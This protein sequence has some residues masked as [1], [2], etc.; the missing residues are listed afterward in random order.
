MS[1]K[2]G[3]LHNHSE[4]SVRD[5]AMHFEQM[6]ARAKELGAPAIALTDHGIL[7]GFY[8]FMKLGVE[9]EI[10]TIPGMEAYYVSDP[11]HDAKK[12]RQHL[13]LMAKDMDG[14]HAI[15]NAVYRSY[16]HMVTTPAGTFPRMTREILNS[17]FGPKS[18][19]YGHVIA[20]SACVNGVLAQLLLDKYNVE[21]ET[22]SLYD[23][24]DKYHPI[25][26]ELLV[27]IKTEKDLAL[28]IDELIAERESLT[29]QSKV[30]VTGLKCRLKTLDTKSAEYEALNLEIKKAE[31]KKAEAKTNSASVKKLIAAKKRAKT[32]YSKSISKIKSSAEHWNTY[33][34]KIESML[35]SAKSDD[36]M[37]RDTLAAA[38]DFDFIFGHG[39]FF[40]ELQYHHINI[41]AMTMPILAK[42]A[43]ETGIPVVA[44]NDA[45]YATNS[46]EDIRA[47]TLVLTMLF[48]NQKIDEE[49]VVLEEGYGELYMKTDEELTAVLSEIIDKNIVKQAMSNIG[50]IIDSC[51]VVVENGDHYP[52]FVGGNPG[53]TTAQRLRRLAKT[54]ISK[55]YPGEMWTKEYANRMEYE[56][57]IIESMGYSDYLC[58]VQDF[59]EY[60]RSL[61][62]DCPEE[63]GYTIG[64]GRG[65][66]VGSIV[67]YL[68]GITSVDPMRYGLLFERFLNPERVSMP[69]IDSD[70]HTEVRSKVI[71]YVKAKYGE[72]AV[73]NILTKGTMAGKSAIR[74]VGR[75]TNVPDSIIDT[76][77]GMIPSTSNA[78]IDDAAELTDLCDSNPVAK[79]LVDDAKLVEGTIVNYGMHAAG[80][81][82]SDNGDVSKYVAV[83]YN[84]SKEQWVAQCDMG[85]AEAD[86]GLLKMDFLGLNNLDIITDTVRRIKRNYGISIDIEAV[87][88]EPAVFRNI[89]ARGRTNSVFQFE[90]DGM[91]NMLR[92]FQPDSMEDIILLVAA[93][94]PGP[95][96]DIPNMIKVKHGEMIPHYI[97]DG[98]EEILSLTYG[99]PIYQEQ[100]MQIFNKVA[101]FSLGESDIIRRA[102]S[103]K[104][105]KILTDPKTDYHGKFITG[106]QKRGASLEDAEA[107]WERLLDFASYAFNKSHAAAYAHVSYYTA[108]L[109]YHYP[110]EYMCSVM[111]RTSYEKLPKLVSE[112]RQMGLTIAAPDI[113]RSFNEF[114]NADKTVLFGFGNIKGVGNSGKEIIQRRKNG[115]PF[116]SMKDF[117]SRSVSYAGCPSSIDKSSIITLIESGAFD[118]FCHGNRQSLMNGIKDLL[119]SA[120]KFKEQKMKVNNR[121]KEVQKLQSGKDI[122]EKAL[123]K[124]T[125]S[126]QSAMKTMQKYKSLYDEHVFLMLPEDESKRLSREYEL[127]GAYATGSPLDEYEESIQEVPTVT[128]IDDISKENT[129]ITICGM[130]SG[131]RV[132][133]R[134][135]DGRPFCTMKVFDKTGE[136]EVKVFTKEYEKF[137]D[138]VDDGAAL[139]ID[140]QTVLENEFNSDEKVIVIKTTKIRKLAIVRHE[141]FLISAPTIADWYNNFD[142]IYAFRQDDGYELMFYDSMEQ[143]IRICNFRV[144]KDILTLSVPNLLVSQLS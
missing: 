135:S 72:K 89:F 71:D 107:F 91:K 30:S 99:F 11:S 119:Q 133:Q 123:K 1:I 54:G 113:N 116:T 143:K 134:K 97:A 126:V 66:A 60:G 15:C 101:G 108:W 37:Y 130:V 38:K 93:Y 103:K 3:I 4:F 75:V 69:D 117:I 122:D 82:I 68:S 49:K 13:I 90:S 83:M 132:F 16:E 31:A 35:S 56:L 131:L 5:S 144:S 102:M 94:R 112:C 110:A 20:T 114:V 55:R 95:M 105:L 52:V 36:E 100:V 73:C 79:S 142:A 23:K 9:Y 129:K 26:A 76:V 41:E 24:R 106:L 46:F 67:C 19:G 58:I 42:I 22:K 21:Q 77:A 125:N 104:K 25:D 18:D 81:I 8:D 127:L 62:Y 29:S 118:T 47:R 70:F 88:L 43:V 74:N 138:I 12:T 139:I 65:S 137:G 136:I 40:I 7:A 85:Q 63:I 34:D 86:A 44:A 78:R 51:N 27:S 17:C 59:L 64:P 32:E 96:S 28:E 45:H 80:V 109:K 61:G 115:G 87:P 120:K 33:N 6:F 48:K 92:K 39:N 121:E 111:T 84:D 141:R 50:V 140:G 14:Y 128:Y 53:E 2:H 124:A 98:L 57:D 10:K